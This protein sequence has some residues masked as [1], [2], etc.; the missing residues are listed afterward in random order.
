M[1]AG[2]PI[3]HPAADVVA[4]TPICPHTL[5]N[6]TIIFRDSVKLRVHSKSPGRKAFISVDGQGTL[7]AGFNEPISIEIAKV[8]LPLAQPRGYS[9]F[10][11]VRTKLKWSGGAIEREQA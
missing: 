7:K 9:H 2:G 1:S 6:R 11:V 8:T 5:S 4:M 10:A 3:L